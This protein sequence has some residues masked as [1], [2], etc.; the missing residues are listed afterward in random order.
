MTRAAAIVTDIGSATGHMASLAREYRVP[1]IVDCG[2]AT[3]RLA[4]GEEVT[5]D[6]T[7]RRVYAGRVEELLVQESRPAPRCD[8][9]SLALVERVVTRV[10]RLN[11]TDP[12]KNSFRAKSC[13]TY[14]DVTRFCH[15]M[16][17]SEMFNLN[18]YR[19]L[20]HKGMAF[21]LESDIPLGIYLIDLGGGLDAAADSRVVRPEQIASLPMRA[22]WRGMTTPGVTW[23]G[24]RPIDLK[25]FV[26]VWAN[27]MYD[28]A[29][30]ERGL[31]A[32]SYAIVAANY[33][34]FGS[35]LGYHFTT[36]DAVCSDRFE[37]NYILFRFKGGAADIERRVRRTRFVAEVLAQHRFD[38][39]Q[40]A[41]LLNAWAK[42]LSRP[43]AEEHL[44]MVGRLIGCARQ[45]DVVMDGEA[46]LD[47]CV[48]A[49]LRGDYGF[50]EFRGEP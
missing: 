23:S 43:A 41:D 35:R 1:A 42:K 37:D 27:T 6:A 3:A 26:S 4:A 50:F 10:A 15:E 39:D 29:K 25:G 34:N 28:A 46:T 45:L 12:S 18:D 48:D 47:R 11:L 32:N 36:L 13:R 24:A 14:H 9:P 33:L 49:F 22:L 17:I 8:G 44:S 30:S 21:R 16:A 40:K 5:V 38:V 20:R 19:N 2:L 7:H 31:G